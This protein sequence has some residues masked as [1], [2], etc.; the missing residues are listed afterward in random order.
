MVPTTTQNMTHVKR[1]YLTQKLVG[2]FI[3]VNKSFTNF[4]IFLIVS[5][6]LNSSLPLRVRYDH[7]LT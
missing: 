1:R 2:K 5:A 6:T 4:V 7:G 3:D